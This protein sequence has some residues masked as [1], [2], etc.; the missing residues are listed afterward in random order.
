MFGLIE[1]EVTLSWDEFMKLP[2]TE[3]IVD[4]HCVTRWSKLD[5]KWKGVLFSDLL[6]LVQPKPNATHV[7]QHCY[8][9]YTTNLSIEEMMDDDVMLSYEFD[10]KPLEKEHG[11][12]MRVVVPKLYFWKSA[13]WVNGL[14]FMSADKPGFWERNGYHMHGDPWTEERYGSFGGW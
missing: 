5:T 14:E 11:G 3:M 4:I 6:K 1:K 13:K 8:G 2:Q 12:P 10:G 9:G 7:M